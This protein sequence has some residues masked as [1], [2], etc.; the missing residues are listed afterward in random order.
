MQTK[1]KIINKHQQQYYENIDKS[2]S[3]RLLKKFHDVLKKM[4]NR[5]C[6]KILDIGGGSGY[7]SSLVYEY[8]F[9]MNID[10]EVF[11]IDTIKYD[12]WRNKI[13]HGKITFIEVSAERLSQVFEKETFD[14]VFAKY[15]FHHFVK[16]TWKKSIDCMTSIIMQI[17]YIIKKDSYLCIVDQFY[18][19]LL[20]DTSASRMIYRFTSCRK[21]FFVK[22]FKNMGAQSAGVGVCFLSKKMWYKLFLAANFFVEKIEE[23][24]PRK[25][26]WY[27]HIGLLL[28]TWNDG[29]VI[30][31]NS[32]Q[33][34]LTEL[35][36]CKVS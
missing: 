1:Q 13:F 25:M 26:K 3:V 35:E 29:C 28:R 24:L 14:I 30:I 32:G 4:E 7:F 6:I 11:V 17:K 20:G 22:I 31:A 27:M 10:C 9:D 21:S 18:N 15:V 5:H 34:G 8:F 12:T 19:G 36:K 23:P 33:S 16:D 2:Y